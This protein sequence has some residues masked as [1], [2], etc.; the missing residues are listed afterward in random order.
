MLNING[1]TL[2]GGVVVSGGTT[3]QVGVT[4]S[5]YTSGTLS[6]SVINCSGKTTGTTTF[7]VSSGGFVVSG[8]CTSAITPGASA[9]LSGGGSAYSGTVT[10]LNSIS[11]SSKFTINTTLPDDP[12]ESYSRF[13]ADKFTAMDSGGVAS[14]NGISQSFIHGY[15]AL[16]STCLL[17]INGVRGN[18]DESL[19][20]CNF[21]I[22]P[23]PG[24]WAEMLE[25]YT[26]LRWR[27]CI[28]CET[29]NELFAAQM[30]LYHAVD[31]VAWQLLDNG[32]RPNYAAPT[33]PGT[34]YRYQG[35]VAYWN[36][37]TFSDAFLNYNTSVRENLAANVG[38][39]NPTC[40]PT[41]MVCIS[42]V[43]PVSFNTPSE[44]RGQLI[45]YPGN[46]ISP[47]INRD[48]NTSNAGEPIPFV[49]ACPGTS[50][51][52]I[53]CPNGQPDMGLLS[54]VQYNG[55]SLAGIISSGH[56]ASSLQEFGN[57][58][59]TSGAWIVGVAGSLGGQGY[60]AQPFTLGAIGDSAYEIND[61]QKDIYSIDNQ[62]YTGSDGT[63][64][65]PYRKAANN[66]SFSVYALKL[67]Q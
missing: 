18:P 53:Y 42:V 27:P 67:P 7:L 26:I 12:D 40:D 17:T 41:Y 61:T 33:A 19:H 11:L 44:L 64:V 38:Y 32:I 37:L 31:H 66:S 9:A 5:F 63:L 46:M 10:G 24:F 55:S 45:F 13:I 50:G 4:S 25:D 21:T 28:T 49:I 62:W 39:A 47:S 36:F 58:P 30:V 60:V 20:T 48:N 52:Y 57:R 51:A 35:L 65:G 43:T 15:S 8:S 56:M 14:F 59:I 23:S 22:S 54:Q 1:L 29:Y 6:S 34:W 3:L 16:S 2:S